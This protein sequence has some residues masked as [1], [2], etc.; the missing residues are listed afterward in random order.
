MW[1]LTRVAASH[2][3][4]NYDEQQTP[5]SSEAIL[6]LGGRSAERTKLAGT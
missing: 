1:L 4:C 2:Y 6:V 5:A 3:G